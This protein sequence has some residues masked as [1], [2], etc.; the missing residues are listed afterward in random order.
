[1]NLARYLMA[2][3]QRVA[4]QLPPRRAAQAGIKKATISRAEG[5][6]LHARVGRQRKGFV[7]SGSDK[8]PI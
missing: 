3:V 1:M 7:A 6:Q 4:H 2:A 8:R 5:G